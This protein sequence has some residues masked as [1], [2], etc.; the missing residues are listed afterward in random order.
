MN[1]ILYLNMV[2][3]TTPM[4]AAHLWGHKKMNNSSK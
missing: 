3:N 4:Q 1:Y 2:K